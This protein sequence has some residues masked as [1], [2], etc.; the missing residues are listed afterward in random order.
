MICKR[1]AEFSIKKSNFKG[2]LSDRKGGKSKY[3]FT[4][5]HSKAY[6]EIDFENDVFENNDTKC[7]Y[8]IQTETTIFYI[9]LKGSDVKKGVEQLLETI[10]ATDKCFENLELKARLIVSKYPQPDIVRK[11]KEYKDLVKKLNHLEGKNE[12][13]IIKTSFTDNI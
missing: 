2:S 4:N 9:E 3:S 5:P 13:L 12:K 11:T 1:I 8:G 6:Y 10:K 7:D